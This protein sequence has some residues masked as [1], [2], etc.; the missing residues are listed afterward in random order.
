[1]QKAKRQALRRAV[2]D[3]PCR[4]RQAETSKFRLTEVPKTDQQVSPIQKP[5]LYEAISVGRGAKRSKVRF[6]DDLVG[7]A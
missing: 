4:G 2:T 6:H 1:L 3:K 5:Q 7:Y